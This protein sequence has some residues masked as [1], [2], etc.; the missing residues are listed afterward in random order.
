[1][2]ATSRPGDM[3]VFGCKGMRPLWDAT[4]TEEVPE[5]IVQYLDV[6]EHAHRRMVLLAVHGRPC[7]TWRALV[8]DTGL[9]EVSAE[10]RQSPPMRP[11]TRCCLSPFPKRAIQ[12]AKSG[13][14][15]K[16]RVRL[17]CVPLAAQESANG[18]SKTN[19]RG[20]CYRPKAA[21]ALSYSS[22]LT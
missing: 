16:H 2:L 22:G 12:V 21:T 4:S 11:S 6:G 8:L 19:T 1:M 17:T 7:S 14:P 5:S 15:P 20:R 9:S 10:F 3:S 18:R 13:R